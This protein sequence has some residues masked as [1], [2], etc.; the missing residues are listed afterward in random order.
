VA[1][2]QDGGGVTGQALTDAT[3]A[4]RDAIYEGLLVRKGEVLT[5]AVARE[6]AN[7]ICMGVIEALR[8]LATANAA[9]RAVPGQDVIEQETDDEYV[10]RVIR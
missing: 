7:N 5:E 4:V 6:R 1:G 10:R 2:G 8:E 9:A 3:L